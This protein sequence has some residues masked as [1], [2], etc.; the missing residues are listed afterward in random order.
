MGSGLQ[1]LSVTLEKLAGY[2]SRSPGRDRTLELGEL[3]G[4]N[5][6]WSVWEVRGSVLEFLLGCRVYLPWFGRDGLPNPGFLGV[7]RERVRLVFQ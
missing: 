2:Y 6:F 4:F 7:L 5:F 1:G 3:P